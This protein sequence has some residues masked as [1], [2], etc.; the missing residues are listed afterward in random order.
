MKVAIVHYHLGHGGVAQTIRSHS[1]ALT[2]DTIPH[3]ILVGSHLPEDA[4]LPI[5][6]IPALDYSSPANPPTCPSAL[7]ASLLQTATR[8]LGAPPDLWH[9]HN[10]S[11]G[12]NP[13]LTESV[14]HLARSGERLLLSIHDLAEDGR[15]ALYAA[16]RRIPDLYPYSPHIHYSFLNQRDI[17]AFLSA[18]LPENQAILLEGTAQSY[19]NTRNKTP[20][21]ATSPSALLTSHSAL[22]ASS[23]SP[24]SNLAPLLFAPIRAIRRKNIGE[25]ILLAVLLPPPVRI[26]ISRPPNDPASLSIHET[27]RAFAAIHAPRIDFAVTDRI[28]PHPEADNSFHSWVHH[29]T[30]LVG[31][32]I[33]EGLGLPFL[34]AKAWNR[35]FLGRRLPHLRHLVPPGSCYDRLLIPKEWIAKVILREQLET[36]LARDDRTRR[37]HPRLPYLEQILADLTKDHWLDF[38]N[39]PEALQ[40]SVIERCAAPYEQE[41]IHLDINGTILPALPWLM[42]RTV[43]RASRPQPLHSSLLTSH[44]ALGT[45][46]SPLSPSPSPLLP[47]YQSLLSAPA[48][49]PDF[50]PPSSILNTF[51][52]PQ[53]FHFLTAPPAP[54]HA[55]PCFYKAVIFDIYGTLLHTKAGAVRPDP[56]SDP[57]LSR[58]IRQL[59]FTPPESPTAALHKAVLQYHA[60]SSEEFPE[61]DLRDLWR[62][63]LQPPPHADLY[64][65]VIATEDIRSPARP[66]PG[67]FDAVRLIAST[68]IRLGL[69]SN[70]Q[71][72]ALHSLEHIT[73]LFDPELTLLSHQLGIAKPSPHIFAE[74]ASRLYALHIA[75]HEVLYI[76]NDPDH[77]ILPAQH[78]GWHTALFSQAP[79]TH[80]HPTLTFS[81]YPQLLLHLFPRKFLNHKSQI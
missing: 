1:A 32:S 63:L 36:T 24:I 69:L 15:P 9:I 66:I 37:C 61:V 16:I 81:H 2:S 6:L 39:L 23:Q 68:G 76:G 30:H 77:D 5:A 50:L 54:F 29:A 40:Q 78:Q 21:T 53:L 58:M 79:T 19:Q 4:D 12:K 38:A 52:T 71:C 80:C 43:A 17:T 55:E 49:A 72:N 60:A 11:L 7:A 20:V 64:R 45:S 14:A 57:A 74:M 56:S 31:S 27:W 10:H 47:L 51:H 18:G 8:H 48:S 44:S 65:L 70:A 25:L 26:A 73:P 28:S 75:P 41:Q 3:V 33:A 46:S 13:Y 42:A 62:N 34:E 59:G 22:G 35:P 67:A